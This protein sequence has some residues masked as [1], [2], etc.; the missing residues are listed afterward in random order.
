[1]LTVAICLRLQIENLQRC[2]SLQKLDFTIS[3]EDMERLEDLPPVDDY[4]D[5][6]IMP[7]FG[8]KLTIG[9]MVKMVWQSLRA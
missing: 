8:G 6:G 5:A 2:E 9:N 4:G 3:D 7:V 1:M